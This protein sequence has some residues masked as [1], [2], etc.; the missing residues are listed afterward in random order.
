MLSHFLTLPIYVPLV[1]CSHDD[2]YYFWHLMHIPAKDASSL[3][4][5]LE[6]DFCLLFMFQHLMF[7]QSLNIIQHKMFYDSPSWEN[8]F[9]IVLNV[10]QFIKNK[11][12]LSFSPHVPSFG[13]SSLFKYNRFLLHSVYVM[14][15]SML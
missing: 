15:S 13:V 2:R 14:A 6:I 8:R 3:F 12:S 7:R 1:S 5:K 11:I 9:V 10:L 4:S